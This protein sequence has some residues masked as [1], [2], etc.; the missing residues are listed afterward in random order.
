MNKQTEVRIIDLVNHVVAGGTCEDDVVEC[1]SQLPED[2]RRAARQIAGLLN[3]ARGA[4]A[5]WIVGLDEKAHQVVTVQ[6]GPDPASWLPGVQKY[7]RGL[8]PDPQIHTI[9]TDHGT[10]TA[11]IFDT[12]R[13]PYV[14]TTDG[15][16]G[17]N[18]EVPWRSATGTG[19]ATRAQLL[20]LV[21][22]TRALPTVQFIN[23]KLVAAQIGS[24]DTTLDFTAELFFSASER[25]FLPRHQWVLS[26]HTSEWDEG[27]SANLEMQF[28]PHWRNGRPPPLQRIR[29]GTS[30]IEVTEVNVDD[31][32]EQE[33]PYGVHVRQ[34]GLIVNGSDSVHL[35]ASAALT[36]AQARDVKHAADFQLELRM[37][38]D[39]IDRTVQEK[40]TLRW[41]NA[42]TGDKQRGE[43]GRWTERS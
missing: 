34:A 22:A 33:H 38:V 18:L 9:V 17:G 7:F 4:T 40:L 6:N 21:V 19:S 30:G 42:L 2:T 16:K 23:P 5:I 28:Y 36:S 20:S 14:V 26:A 39:R 10:V 25:V 12:E 11:L 41:I 8:D 27:M 43:L 1:K 29:A 3:A 13:A 15:G 24:D 37:P 35:R 32:Y 31:Y